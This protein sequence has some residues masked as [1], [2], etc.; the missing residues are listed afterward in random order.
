MKNCKD[1]CALLSE[2]MDRPLGWRERFSI[3]LHFMLCRNCTRFLQHLQFLRKTAS[4]YK[5][6]E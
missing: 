4:R 5:P 2:S 3:K 1:I 6:K